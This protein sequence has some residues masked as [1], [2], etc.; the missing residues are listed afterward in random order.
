MTT[1]TLLLPQEPAVPSRLEAALSSRFLTPALP[2]IE[3]FLLEVRAEIDAR[4]LAAPEKLVR[5]KPYPVGYCLEITDAVVEALGPRLRAPDHPGARAL[6]AYEAA[7]GRHRRIWGVL[8]ERYFQNAMQFGSLYI[9]VA[10]DTVTPTKPKVEIL[11]MRE[12]GMV[13]VRDFRHY[14]EIGALYWGRT[15]VANHALPELAPMY[16]MIAVAPDRRPTLHPTNGYMAEMIRR[17]GFT[18]SEQWVADAPPPS[19]ETVEALRAL[20]PPDLL[21]ANPAPGRDEAIAACRRARTGKVLKSDT[22]RRAQ[23]EAM[24]RIPR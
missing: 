5:R 1:Q 18:L 17:S 8:R 24:S 10:N 6:R 22:W 12:A 9:D 11:P 19:A 23:F 13:A 14:A 21:A 20:C 2:A 16:P 7:G 4:F 3:A 15:I